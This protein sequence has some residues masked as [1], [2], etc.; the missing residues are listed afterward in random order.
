MGKS[1]LLR[2]P[3]LTQSGYGVHARQ[4]AQWLFAKEEEWDLDISCELLNWGQ[5]G[6]VLDHDAFDGLA[7]KAFHASTNTKPLYDVTLQLQLPNEWNPALGKFNV[8][9]T[10]GV[11]TDKCNP[12]WIQA[13]NSMHLVIVPSQFVKA[14]FENTGQCTTPIVVVP[15]AFISECT[16][17]GCSIDLDIPTSFNFLVFGQVTG[18]N[19]ENDRKNLAYTVKW[20]AEVFH[21]KPDVGVILK[22]NVARNSKVDAVMTTNMLSKLIMEVKKGPGPKF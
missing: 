2:A 15:E 12:A 22:T 1:V 16:K 20:L 17:L 21:N 13:V 4:I 11:E 9:I 18:N 8:G 5:T 7:L 19:P 3:V 10:A 6:W 14:S